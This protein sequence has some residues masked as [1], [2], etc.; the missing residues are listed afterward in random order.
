MSN[1]IMHAY[2]E[3]SVRP[4]GV[5][6]RTPRFSWKIENCQKMQ[7]FYRVRVAGSEKDLLSGN[8]IWDTGKTAGSQTM[9]VYA[10]PGLQS[11]AE[12]F[13]DIE[14]WCRDSEQS[15]KSG[16]E[17][18]LTALYEKEDWL[19]RFIGYKDYV[20][21]ESF[22]LVKKFRIRKNLDRAYA[23]ICGPGYSEL[24]INNSKIGDAVL[25]PGWTDYNRRVLYTVYDVTRNVSKGANLI[26]VMLGEGWLGHEHKFFQI[27]FGQNP[28]WF[29]T[30][31]LLMNLRLYYSDGTQETIYTDEGM[32]WYAAKGPV[33]M[34]NIY[35]GETYDARLEIQLPEADQFKAD[36]RFTPAV[37]QDGPKGELYRDLLPPIKRQEKLKAHTVYRP[38][39][40]S[41]TI[42]FGKN[43]AGWLRLRVRGEAGSKIVVKY[44]ETINPDFTVNQDNLRNAR[45][46]DEYIL[47]GEGEEIYEPRFTYH[48]FRYAQIF[49]QSNCALLNAT[50]Y[51]VNSSVRRTGW[52]NCDNPM[53]NDIYQTIV[54]TERNNLHSVPTDCPQRDERL[55][56]LN[57]MTVR[58]EEAMYNYDMLLFYEKWLR[59][60]KDAQAGGAN[61]EIGD[62]APYFYGG[63]PACHISSVYVLLPYY[64]YLFYNDDTALKEHYQGMKKYV[65]FM[66]SQLDDRG[67]INRGYV[68]EWAP[69]L[70]ESAFSTTWDALPANIDNQLVTT[71]YLYYCLAVMQRSA[72]HLNLNNE[73]IDYSQKAVALKD[74][75]NS[76]FFDR[77]GYYVPFSQGSNVFPM[78]LRIIPFGADYLIANMLIEDIIQENQCHVTT[79]SQL[80][81]YLFEVL[82]L[83]KRND[84][85]VQIL[86]RKDYP[87][88]GYMLAN[89]ATSLWERWENTTG[90]TMNSHNHPMQGAFCPWFFKAL[91]GIMPYSL[92]AN[93]YITINPDFTSALDRVEG[94]VETMSGKI[95]S[96]WE[97]RGSTVT[98]R[99]SLPFNTR[100]R[101]LVP[102]CGKEPS[103]LSLNGEN[104]TGKP[105]GGAAEYILDAGEYTFILG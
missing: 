6:S 94:T 59:D 78:F 56:W 83:I 5:S 75:I 17:Y 70:S 61:G 64:I 77:N 31:C 55:A 66:L 14:V 102:L 16:T 43:I 28:S 101:V 13:Y 104:Y 91:A 103:Q 3:Y 67:L 53:L 49:V 11:A 38:T 80:T 63:R 50:A 23:F 89:G 87:S 45:A 84:I 98:F 100:A 27:V 69:P 60:I 24:Y 20:K 85:G 10:G 42:D 8:V 72:D 22:M 32:K 54:S 93:G 76:A 73:S 12:Y 52:F 90:R 9:C 58:F 81:K 82:N 46:A 41:M 33:I 36:E 99:L 35:D 26:S 97:R 44:S 65:D 86:S 39:E 68:G 15:I 40:D 37:A 79:G 21:R 18:F 88:I 62:T 25:E 74:N 29:G 2:C 34:N 95:T 4:L 48:G 7:T 57:D 96:K 47:K 19:G 71:C 30:P 105:S 92:P 1:I 51:R